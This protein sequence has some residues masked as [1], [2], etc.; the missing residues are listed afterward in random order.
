LNGAPRLSGCGSLGRVPDVNVV[1]SVCWEQ[2][3]KHGS[4]IGSH[5]GRVGG[6][7]IRPVAS[8]GK[9]A[10]GPQAGECGIRG[11]VIE[12]EI[13]PGNRHRVECDIGHHG[14]AAGTEVICGNGLKSVM[15]GRSIG[16]CKTVEVI[17]GGADGRA[18]RKISDLCNYAVVIVGEPPTTPL[19]GRSSL[20]TGAS[21]VAAPVSHT[22][23]T[24]K[25][26]KAAKRKTLWVLP[27]P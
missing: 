23:R 1:E 2:G 5:A 22:E 18:P 26:T 17:G 14:S 21:L 27:L 7:V 10:R 19:Y 3:A 6:T 15:P 16:P 13:A 9:T 11:E 20:T 12:T 24:T 8:A 4:G 25:R